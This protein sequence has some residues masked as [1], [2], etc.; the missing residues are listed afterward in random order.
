M[1][2][3]YHNEADHNTACPEYNV[4]SITGGDPFY[5][6]F[7]WFRMIGR[8]FVY[9]SNL[10][11]PVPLIHKVPVVSEKGDVRGFLRIAVQPVLVRFVRYS[12]NILKPTFLG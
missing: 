10:L 4:E 1:R 12:N 2:E 8:A 11:H 5:D 3:M 6:R 9:L 7:P